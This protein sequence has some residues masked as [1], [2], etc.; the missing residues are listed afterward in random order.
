MTS[1][2]FFTSLL[3]F[4]TEEAGWFICRWVSRTL[5][6]S[7]WVRLLYSIV[8]WI[9]TQFYPVMEILVRQKFWS[10]G[11]NFLEN[12]SAGPL[13]SE[14]FGPHV[15]LWSERKMC[16]N[17]TRVA[18]AWQLCQYHIHGLINAICTYWWRQKLTTLPKPWHLF[19][20][21]CTW[22]KSRVIQIVHIVPLKFASDEAAGWK[23]IP[24]NCDYTEFRLSGVTSQC[25]LGFHRGIPNKCELWCHDKRWFLSW[26]EQLI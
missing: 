6:E 18:M 2:I 5:S 20:S 14:N 17:A 21:M 15:E 13:F 7:Y 26:W 24:W 4:L 12:W 3:M 16:V 1:C 19:G 22:Q 8:I 10:G 25:W 11:P 9:M 23:M